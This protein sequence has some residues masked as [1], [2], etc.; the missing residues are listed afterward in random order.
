MFRRTTRVITPYSATEIGKK[1]DHATEI[2]GKIG[3]VRARVDAQ[4]KKATEAKKAAKAEPTILAWVKKKK[5]KE[6]RLYFRIYS[7]NTN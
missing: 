3:H 6:R 5:R 7:L 4:A 2:N 1:Y